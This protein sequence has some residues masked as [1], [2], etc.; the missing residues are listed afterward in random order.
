MKMNAVLSASALA[1]ATMIAPAAAN[2]IEEACEAYTEEYDTG[3]EGCACL[4][5]KAEGDEDLKEAILAVE[6]PEDYEASPDILK[7]AVADCA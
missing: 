1:F 5:E 2:E 4:A 7:E 6:T 3:F